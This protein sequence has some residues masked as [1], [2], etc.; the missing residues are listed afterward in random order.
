[1]SASK[2]ERS[3]L[4]AVVLFI[5]IAAALLLVLLFGS[6]DPIK[7]AKLVRVISVISI[8]L[9]GTGLTMLLFGVARLRQ[10]LRREIE[11]DNAPMPPRRSIAES[12]GAP[13][14]AALPPL[15]A[16]HSVTEVT[17]DLLPQEIKRAS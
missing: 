10:M 14:T 7:F 3:G 11:P 15:S 12:G 1:M 17:T 16:S 8:T 4:P 2:S 9:G 5:A 13:T 6:N